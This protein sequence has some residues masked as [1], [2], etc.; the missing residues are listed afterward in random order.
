MAQEAGTFWH[1][2][3]RLRIPIDRLRQGRMILVLCMKKGIHFLGAANLKEVAPRSFH[4]CR[5]EPE[6]S[7]ARR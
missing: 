1:R 2:Q 4:P 7:I 6:V 3:L 5:G